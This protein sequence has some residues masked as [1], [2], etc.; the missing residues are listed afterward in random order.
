MFICRWNEA[1][2]GVK[3]GLDSVGDMASRNPFS[4][5]GN[6]SGHPPQRLRGEQGAGG[7][8]AMETEIREDGQGKKDPREWWFHQENSQAKIHTLS[9]MEDD[10]NST[11]LFEHGG[12]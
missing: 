4:Q 7:L 1:T 9:Y 5:E 12:G 3:P 10:L 8:G 11:L 2:R 6:H